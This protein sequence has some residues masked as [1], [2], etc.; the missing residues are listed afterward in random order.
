M[1]QGYCVSF[2]KGTFF[3]SI[4][5]FFVSKHIECFCYQIVSVPTLSFYIFYFLLIFLIFFIRDVGIAGCCDPLFAFVYSIFFIHIRID[6]CIRI[7]FIC[8]DLIFDT[9]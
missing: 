2:S 6:M 3:F 7:S 4:L 8:S 5:C 1:D 9:S